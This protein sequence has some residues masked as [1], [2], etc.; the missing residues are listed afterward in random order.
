MDLMFDPH[1]SNLASPTKFF[2]LRNDIS[3]ALGAQVR[4]LKVITD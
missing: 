4:N 2:T 1:S 3:N